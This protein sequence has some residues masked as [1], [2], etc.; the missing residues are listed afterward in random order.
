[1]WKIRMSKSKIRRNSN[2]QIPEEII[3]DFRISDF[4]EFRY[5]DFEFK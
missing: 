1:M 5:S 3:S 4:F 2:F